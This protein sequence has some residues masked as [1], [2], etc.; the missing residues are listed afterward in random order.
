MKFYSKAK[1]LYFMIIP[2]RDR[3]NHFYYFLLL[4]FINKWI[5]VSY[6]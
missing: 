4:S 5:S 2:V 1:L 6:D 3:K